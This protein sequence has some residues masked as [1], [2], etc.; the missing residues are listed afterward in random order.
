[1]PLPPVNHIAAATHPRPTHGGFPGATPTLDLN[2]LSLLLMTNYPVIPMPLPDT[3]Y[4]ANNTNPR[5]LHGGFP[6]TTPTLLHLPSTIH[7]PP[8]RLTPGAGTSSATPISPTILISYPRAFKRGG[9]RRPTPATHISTNSS[10]HLQ[11]TPTRQASLPSP[12]SS[13]HHNYTSPPFRGLPPGAINPPP[14]LS[15]RN[16]SGLGSRGRGV[17]AQPPPAPPCAATPCVCGGPQHHT[18]QD[19][20]CRICNFGFKF[21]APCGRA[22]TSVH[23]P[24]G[25]PPGPSPP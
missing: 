19:D 11:P 8:T 15:F 14:T 16:N 3:N 12:S 7:R 22:K 5:P 23:V 6:C 10:T 18:W 4:S 1:M 20:L 9:K 2:R 24:L 17:L 25:R 13:R 21:Q